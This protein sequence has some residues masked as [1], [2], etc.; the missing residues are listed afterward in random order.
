[1]KKGD[2]VLI[3]STVIIE[4]H[5]A[6]CW[7]A[8]AGFFR[9]ETVET[10]VVECATGDLRKPGR[11][12]IDSAV[13]QRQIAVHHVNHA[14]FARAIAACV[15]LQFLDAGEK[16]LLAHAHNHIKDA[17]LISSQD[18]GCVRAGHILGF[19]D[20]FVSLEEMVF[21]VG[22]KRQFGRQFT[23]KWLKALR[24]ELKLEQL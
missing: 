2:I 22:L 8:L 19:L 18:A 20:R 3:D 1:M 9:L 10:C 7:D 11:V 14:D 15:R 5:K 21:S 24:T 4:A 6:T 17:W 13:L 16:E 23:D 12:A